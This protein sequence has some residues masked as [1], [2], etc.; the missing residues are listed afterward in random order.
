MRKSRLFPVSS[1]HTDQTASTGRVIPCMPVL[2]WR[3]TSAT[4]PRFR[5][6][7]GRSSLPRNESEPRSIRCKAC[8]SATCGQGRL[9]TGHGDRSISCGWR[10]AGARTRN[11]R[12]RRG[13]SPSMRLR[14]SKKSVA[15][16]R[17]TKG[18]PCWL[19]QRNN[20]AELQGKRAPF[21]T[22]YRTDQSGEQA[23]ALPC[24]RGSIGS[25]ANRGKGTGGNMRHVIREPVEYIVDCP[26]HLCHLH[27]VLI[28][29]PIL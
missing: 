27:V 22:E 5:M 26:K 14:S 24:E 16:S 11:R 15:L 25:T 17:T 3:K 9:R 10:C 7:L 1:Y 13:S 6:L 4:Y 19:S 18:I 29:Q 2:R 28:P 12:R 8:A 20:G 23:L 21:S